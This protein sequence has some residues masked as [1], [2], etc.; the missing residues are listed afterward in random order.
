MRAWSL[1]FGMS[2]LVAPV[3]ELDGERIRLVR[4]SLRDAGDG[5]RRVDCGD[6]PLWIVESERLEP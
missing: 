5:A 2:E 6:G 4:T 3:A 1:T